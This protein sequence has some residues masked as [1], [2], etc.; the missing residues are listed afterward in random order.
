MAPMASIAPWTS[1][2]GSFAPPPAPGQQ[3]APSSGNPF[4]V[5]SERHGFAPLMESFQDGGD[6][7]SAM[8]ELRDEIRALRESMQ[9]LRERI[10]SMAADDR[11]R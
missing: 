3:P 5:A 10:H 2:F 11:L 7:E 1:A 8:H 4:E 9:G 6:L